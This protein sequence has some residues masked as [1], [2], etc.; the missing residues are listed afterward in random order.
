MAL[1]DPYAAEYDSWF[2]TP[3]GRLVWQLELKILLKALKP[4]HGERILD[5]GCGTGN[6]TQE[7][8][9][10][11]AN[12]TGVD[13]SA[14]MLKIARKKMKEGK[15]VFLR[16]DVA[17]LPFAPE[18]FDAAVCFTVLEFTRKPEE[19]LRELWRVIKPGG[20]MVIGMLNRL[21]PWAAARK[22]RGVFVSARFY[23]PREMRQLIL[24]ATSAPRGSLRQNA[25]IYFPP[26]LKGRLL[27]CAGLFE[28]AGRL[29]A[30][31]FGAVIVFRL[32][33]P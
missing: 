33:K 11:G 9:A 5:A 26:G 2:N 17:S 30:R 29:I 13:V 32:D 31:P 28:F 18:S 3:K 21:S 23:S 15:A 16:A 12:V 10:R 27:R 7:L 24:S 14:A 6:L 8:V 20:R 25:A 1:F 22:G 4:C 19:A